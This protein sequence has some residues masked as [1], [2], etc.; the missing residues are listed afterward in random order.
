MATASSSPAPNVDTFALTR[1][2][3]AALLED[4]VKLGLPD[5]TVVPLADFLRASVSAANPD[6]VQSP[7]WAFVLDQATAMLGSLYPHLPFKKQ[8]FNADP[9]GLADTLRSLL[10]H[11]PP[12]IGEL[13][14][15][16][17]MLKIFA[18]VR[19]PHTAYIL[20]RF[21]HGAVA[22]L[23]FRAGFYDDLTTKK[24]RFIV[25]SVMAGF[26]HPDFKPGVELVGYGENMAS[27]VEQ[28]ASLSPGAN[29]T[30]QL[31]RGVL[32]LTV[33]PLATSGSA[34]WHEPFE[35]EIGCISYLVPGRSDP[36]FITFPWAV[37]KSAQ[38]A[39]D[40]PSGAFSMSR[41]LFASR[42]ATSILWN[43]Q[44]YIQTV[45][46]AANADGAANPSEV[47]RF[48]DVF[49][50]QTT[51]RVSASSAMPAQNLIADSAP[52]KKFGYVAIRH[53]NTPGLISVGEDLPAEFQRILR[54]MQN[55]APDGLVIDIR[56][57]PG[58]DIVAAENMLQM[59]TAKPITPANFHL[60]NTA[61]T[62]NV[63][64]TVGQP[65]SPARQLRAWGGSQST[66]GPLTPG[67]PLTPDPNGTGQIYQGPVVL[68][69]DALT[70]SAADIFAGGFAD[71]G[72]GH[73]ISSD[74]ST[75]GGG[76]S[77]WTHGELMRKFQPADLNLQPLPSGI[78]MSL[79]FLRS[80]RVNAQLGRPIED[81][82]VHP[83]IVLPRTLND[84]LASTGNPVL[85]D[86]IKAA[87]DH[88]AGLTPHRI[89]VAKVIE[90][91]NGFQ[92]NVSPVNLTQLE[93]VLDESKIPILTIAA[94][95]SSQPVIVP[96][97]RNGVR[98][99]TI[100]VRGNSAGDLLASLR[101]DV[102][103][104]A[105]AASVLSDNDDGDTG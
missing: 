39:E 76:A 88:L 6:R 41:D 32:R 30:A 7:Q 55:Q 29:E 40:F 57:N 16:I 99:Q 84:L 33:R 68:L 86:L 96:F 82:G 73:I 13:D 77:L 87:C 21:F 1:A 65:L 74:E 45:W 10:K 5:L 35:K 71:N 43:R 14:F 48:P 104:S 12:V 91:D 44:Q 3:W 58:G 11:S 69:V 18:S 31:Q 42:F 78:S 80:S 94:A 27:A 102:D 52:A 64:K 95:A 26:D 47:S 8:D 93:F 59:L 38:L 67:N 19:D 79:A 28:A 54:L 17:Q 66:E 34:G 51:G 37:A 83:D 49:D 70:Y 2:A 36:N 103:S 100:T 9:L 24:R 20:P 72:I 4:R 97:H 98:P 105:S 61:S 101:I 85:S 23:P 60:A 25:T 75:G 56:G 89:G 15:H 53:F 50:F 62:L 22:F 90:V 92:M 63:L 46:A 81:I